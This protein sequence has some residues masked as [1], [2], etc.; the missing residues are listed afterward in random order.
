MGRKFNKH[1]TRE[2]Q[3]I[4][5]FPVIRSEEKDKSKR[6]SWKGWGSDYLS[7]ELEESIEEMQKNNEKE[8]G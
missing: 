1:K 7:E 2:T 5:G 6:N 3:F 4:D 8:D